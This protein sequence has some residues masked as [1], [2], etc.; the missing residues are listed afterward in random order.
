MSKINVGVIGPGLIFKDAIAPVWAEL[1]EYFCVKALCARTQKTLDTVGVRYPDAKK[2]LIAEEMLAD[3]GINAVLVATPI[4]LNGQMC[5]AALKAGKHV[6]AEKPL[7]ATREQAEEIVRLERETGKTVYIVEHFVYMDSVL[8]AEKE[9]KMG[10]IGEPIYADINFHYILD[11]KTFP[12]DRYAMTSWRIKPDYPL[13]SILDGGIHYIAIINYLFGSPDN[14]FA[15]G[16]KLRSTY[17]DYDHIV[18]C[19]NYNSKFKVIFSHSSVFGLNDEHFYIWGTK[20]LMV[21]EK[22]RVV[23]KGYNGTEEIIENC[24]NDG[25]RTMWLQFVDCF[26]KGKLQKFSAAD[27][28]E[29]LK[30]IDAIKSSLDTNLCQSL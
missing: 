16:T 21:V 29:G 11:Y 23:I 7:A 12:M 17:G 1:P 6:F 15:M 8:E 18:T 25:N 3:D 9:L 14:V 30:I 27:A 24:G 19:L 5:I 28:L 2:Y 10:K 13:G 4:H 22:S 20:G 26:V